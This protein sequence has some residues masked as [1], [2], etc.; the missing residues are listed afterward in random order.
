MQKL[1]FRRVSFYRKSAGERPASDSEAGPEPDVVI[2]GACRM[3]QGMKTHF[4]EDTAV[5]IHDTAVQ[6]GC[7]DRL[8]CLSQRCGQ[9][10]T[11]SYTWLESLTLGI[12]S[13]MRERLARETTKKK[14]KRGKR[15]RGRIVNVFV[16]CLVG[17]E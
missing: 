7:D 10:G 1:S 6:I 4:M 3:S 8:R 13:W 14:K 5:M 17:N 9:K 15:I 2:T 12:T 16:S 11:S